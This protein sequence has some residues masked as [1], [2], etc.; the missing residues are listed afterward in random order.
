MRNRAGNLFAS[1]GGALLAQFLGSATRLILEVPS[2]PG[3]L[4]VMFQTY[5]I[6]KVHVIDKSDEWRLKCL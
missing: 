6:V 1:E 4:I 5:V 2:S 3:K